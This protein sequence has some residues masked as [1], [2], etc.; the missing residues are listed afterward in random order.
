MRIEAV[1]DGG[2]FAFDE[3]EGC[4][5]IKGLRQYVPGPGNHRHEGRFGISERMEQ[6]QVVQDHVAFGDSQAECPLLDIADQ[7]VVVH[8]ALGESRRARGVHDE[9]GVVRVDRARPGIE[10]GIRDAVRAGDR[11][12]PVD[13]PRIVSVANDDDALEHREVAVV[14]DVAPFGKGDDLAHHR[15]VVDGSGNIVRDQHG[16]VRLTHDVFEIVGAKPRV[17]G[18]LHCADPGQAEHEKQPVGAVVQPQRDVIAGLYV[19]R[20]QA[21]GRPVHLFGKFGERIAFIAEDQAFAGAEAA[22][23]LPRE[24]AESALWIPVGH[25]DREGASAP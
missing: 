25:R 11:A 21:L 24:I 17:D 7:L 6:G 20:H 14:D 19:K 10:F 9:D 5:G 8:H 4:V 18:H 15:Q 13:S 23:H 2:P 1:A 22:G 3:V 12:S 16:T